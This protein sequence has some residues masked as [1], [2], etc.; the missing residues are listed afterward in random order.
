MGGFSLNFRLMGR[1]FVTDLRREL[2]THWNT[3]LSAGLARTHMGTVNA[4]FPKD[5]L[6]FGTKDDGICSGESRSSGRDGP[7]HPVQAG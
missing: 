5:F 2:G 4:Q 3:S 6:D 1:C 7:F